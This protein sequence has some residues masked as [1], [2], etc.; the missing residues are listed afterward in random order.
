M[1]ELSS[2]NEDLI[3]RLKAS[4][5]RE[6]ALRR[7]I[8]GDGKAPIRPK[9]PENE[10][11]SKIGTDLRQPFIKPPKIKDSPDSAVRAYSFR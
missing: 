8:E 2:Q 9:E 3:V 7:M 6:I 4:M 11:R 10:R 5:E 1:E